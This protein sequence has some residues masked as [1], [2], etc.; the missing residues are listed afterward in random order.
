[1][2]VAQEQD[3]VRPGVYQPKHNVVTLIVI[4]KGITLMDDVNALLGEVDHVVQVSN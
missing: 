1:V 4:T 3:I 2:E